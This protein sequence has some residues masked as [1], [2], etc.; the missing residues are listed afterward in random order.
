M[1]IAKHLAKTSQATS[2]AD[3]IRRLLS[4]TTG[5]KASKNLI[6]SGSSA[7]LMSTT[8]SAAAR[9]GHEM[10]GPAKKMESKDLKGQWPEENVW[11][12][13]R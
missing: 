1:I 4:E 5:L 10:S 8:R 12:Y 9:M 6:Q 7:R 3:L 11:D 13:P 2:Q